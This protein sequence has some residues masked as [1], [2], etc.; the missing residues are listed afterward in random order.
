MPAHGKL[1]LVTP[2]FHP[3]DIVFA[4]GWSRLAP[5]IGGWTVLLDNGEAPEQVSILPPGAEHPVFFATREG[6]DV[7]V[8]RKRA[9]GGD[10]E[11]VEVGRFD[12]LRDAVLA[13]CPIGDDAMEEIQLTLE[14]QF[15]RLGRR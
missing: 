2:V 8:K 3:S 7:V 9:T 6:R 1:L 5:G 11:L 14:K 12:G 10:D 4:R 15:P 13:L